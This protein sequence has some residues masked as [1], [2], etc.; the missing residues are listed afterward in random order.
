[1]VAYHYP[2]CSGS[3]GL[4]RTLSFSKYLGR[5]E[6]EP[7]I[8][9][10]HPRA[11]PEVRHD[12]LRD[13]PPQVH[14]VRAQALDSARHLSIR[15]RYSRLM[16]LPDRWITWW[17]GAIP[18]GLAMI[19]RYKPQVIW[20]SYP[21]A[22]AHLIGYTLHRLTQIPWV[23]DCRDPLTEVD[24]VTGQLYP[25]DPFVRW[26]RRHIERW[27]VV[28]S[29]KMVCVTEG[30]LRLY[31]ARYP[32]IPRERWAL[33]PNGYDEESFRM[34]E[35]IAQRARAQRNHLLLLHSGTLYPA[36][37]RDP[38]AFFAALKLLERTGIVS[39]ATLKVV[40]RSSGYDDLYAK[41]IRE[42]GVEAM[43]SLE[44]ALPYREALAEMMNVDGLLLF[45]G[46][47]SNPAIPAKL[48]E[49]LRAKRPILAMADAAGDT[50]AI[51]RSAKVG[52]LVPLKDVNRIAAG[53]GKF[54]AQISEGTAPVASASEIN[55]HS[56]ESR[57]QELADLLNKIL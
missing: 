14:V 26:A 12:Q 42:Q 19:R 40:L 6:W 8:L 50:A 48:Y 21:H 2:P 18:A 3:S 31:Q 7:L 10:A 32:E 11:Y 4:Q 41:L 39:S 52:Y 43:V 22:T 34:A 15:G 46:Y 13:V 5:Y 16:A 55:R 9:T 54:L 25:T 28:H 53:L 23:A 17:F 24:A 38:T 33:I 1:M 27:S 30:A 29:A 51:L 47:T 44:P 37:D 20:S 35:E 49:Y 45:Q 56:R 57:T 36:E